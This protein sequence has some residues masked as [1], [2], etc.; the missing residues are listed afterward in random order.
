M[1]MLFCQQQTNHVYP[2]CSR[3]N[4]GTY[5]NFSFYRFYFN[6]KDCPSKARAVYADS[7]IIENIKKNVQK[8][9]N[10]DILRISQVIQKTYDKL[11]DDDKNIAMQIVEEKLVSLDSGYRLLAGAPTDDGII[12][13]SNLLPKSKAFLKLCF[14]KGGY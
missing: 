3:Y 8:L 2:A 5:E 7:D 11:N 14:P 9:N 10:N 4:V 1:T 6:K 13:F 12:F